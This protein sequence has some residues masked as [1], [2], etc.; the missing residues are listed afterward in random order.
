MAALRPPF[1]ANDMAGLYKKVVTA[2]YPSISSR[3]SQEFR[4]MISLMLQPN[5]NLRPTTDQ[6]LNLPVMR[7]KM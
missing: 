2:Q 7:D 4:E 6:M 1:K 5:P 3:Y